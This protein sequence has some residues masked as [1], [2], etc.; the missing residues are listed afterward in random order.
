M[1][2][3]QYEVRRTALMNESQE[4]IDQGKITE[5]EEKMNEVRQLDEMWDS[6]S[7]SQANLN[8]LIR[9]PKPVNVFGQNTELLDF[10][11]PQSG[12]ERLDTAE[13]A[14]ASDVYTNAWVKNLTGR[15]LTDEEQNAFRMVNE[16]YTHTT[17][18][19]AIVIP[20]TVTKGI[21][22]EA[23]ELY[24]YYGDVAK[25]YVNG[26]LT[27][28]QG[29]SSSE[30]GWYEEDTETEDG[31]ETFKEFTLSG[32]ELSRA[33]T[34]S[35]KLKE[36]SIEDFIP[37]IQ[38][39]MGEKMGAA[40][41]Y[42]ATHGKGTAEDGKPEPIGVVTAL[43]KEESTPQVITYT[44]D[45]PTFKELTTAR[46]KV[47]SA[48]AND[49]FVYANSSTIWTKL[50]N[51]VDGNKRPIFMPDPSG[52][53]VF[54]IFGMVVKEDASMLDGEVLFSNPAAGY[55]M[56]VNKE[57]TM[58]PEEHVKARKTDY[59]GYAIVDGNVA[60]TKAHALLKKAE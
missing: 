30:A 9:E 16:A 48:Y 13:A 40:L 53:G 34:V 35:W 57:M 18:N 6:I 46:S 10:S 51:I 3:K 44:G 11:A 8:A 36:M 21:W 2:K 1:N 43:E 42:G 14:W 37:Y 56:N 27:M 32:C 50:A 45:A 15:N 28:I 59:C 41:G 38:R 22:D 39:K 55:H 7:Q 12:T 52:N 60:T 29:E 33:I 4:L 19:T 20:K 49:L 58:I 25:T 26:V 47:K 54:R 31:K 17:D 24:P 5:A 23:A